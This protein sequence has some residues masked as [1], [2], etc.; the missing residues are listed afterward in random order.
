MKTIF[1]SVLLALCLVFPILAD[2]VKIPADKPVASI[3]FP[4]GWKAT[5]SGETIA[6][7]NE[8][9]DVLIDVIMT[10]PDMLGPSNDN[11]WALLKVKPDWDTEKNNK[12]TQNGM[13]VNELKID[14]KD[15]GGAAMKLNLTSFEVTKDKGVML[16]IRGKGVEEN[17]DDISAILNSVAAVK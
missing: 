7:S 16:I 12:T 15:S 2:T 5:V 8:E 9:G 13:N 6:A 11:A 17:M 4:E 3:T 14:A 10:R 1:A